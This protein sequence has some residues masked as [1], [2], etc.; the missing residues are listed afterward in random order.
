MPCW[1][2]NGIPA[3]SRLSLI[4]IGGKTRRVG[5]TKRNA[6]RSNNIAKPSKWRRRAGSLFLLLHHAYE[7]NEV[8]GFRVGSQG[9]DPALGVEPIVLTRDSVN[10]IHKEGGS[11]TA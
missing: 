1:P 11:V 8:P 2:L 7:V 10:D 9:L 6:R 4:Q 5:V 3:S